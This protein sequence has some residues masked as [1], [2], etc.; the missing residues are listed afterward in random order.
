M[1]TL[2]AFSRLMLCLFVFVVP[3]LGVE[4]EMVR[5]EKLSQ[6]FVLIVKDNSGQANKDNPIYLASSIN[7]WN[8]SDDEMVLSGRSDTRWQ[9]VI[10]RDLHG[11]GLEFKFTLGGWDRE[12]LDGSG[13][14]ISNRTL[15]LVD[16]SRLGKNERPVIEI[17]IPE[18]RLPVSL[19]E[20][21]RRTGIYRALD[22]SGEV[23]RIEV[24]GGAGGAEASTRDLIVLLPDGYHDHENIGREYP[25]LY[26]FDGQNLFE[27]MPGVPGEWH[28]D[29]T[30][31]SLVEQGRVE[32]MIV[33][34]IPHSGAHRIQEFMPFGSY[35]GIDGDG[36]ACMEW[37]V[38]EVVPKVN[39]AFRVKQDRDA[40]GIGGASLG[41]AMALYGSTTYPE[42][43]G[44]AIIE[45]L[46]MIGQD[47]VVAH[48]DGAERLPSMVVIGMGDS[49]VGTDPTDQNRNT[50]Y[51]QWA[52]EVDRLIARKGEMSSEQHLLIVGDGHVHNE[53]AWSE[54]FGEAI[55]FLFPAE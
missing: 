52:K 3:A 48:I 29:E 34:G 14:A 23:K 9:I 38:R 10:D 19:S 2:S 8:P 42:I 6:G 31:G 47:P 35:K 20:E 25:V 5:P 49:E 39:R 43:F 26:M 22:V 55:E 27:Q 21:V 16:A 4:P 1:S 12:E 50:E 40:T 11:V 13:V 36:A 30:L 41:G 7:G 28:I 33:V 37:V 44:K 15:P 24:R 32:P 45:S 53:S 46:P 51:V 18:F 17:E 54:R